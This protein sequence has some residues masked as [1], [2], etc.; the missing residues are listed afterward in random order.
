MKFTQYSDTRACFVEEAETKDSFEMQD[1]FPVERKSSGKIFE[2]KNNA[3]GGIEPPTP[4]AWILWTSICPTL[5]YWIPAINNLGHIAMAMISI[6]HPRPPNHLPQHIRLLTSP[7]F[8]SRHENLI[9]KRCK[10]EKEA[11]PHVPGKSP[12]P[13]LIRPATA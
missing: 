12:S 11:A 10:K 1:T 6:S 5:Q 4:R 3:T 8:P 7:M 9:I 2:C 13:V